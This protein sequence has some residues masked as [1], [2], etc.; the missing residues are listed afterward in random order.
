MQFLGEFLS[1]CVAFSWTISAIA[2]EIAGRR[3]GVVVLNVWR[4]ILALI[5][6]MLLCQV[7]TGEAFP[8]YAD[9]R[10]WLWLLLSGVVG[11]F[12]GD[13]CLFNCYLTVGARYGQLFM[14]LAPMFTAL[15]AWISLGQQLSWQ[16]LL[17]MVVTMSGIVV[18]VLGRSEGKRVSL[19]LPLKGVLFGVGAGLG[20]GLGLVLSK[21]GLDYYTAGVPTDVL[22]SMETFLPFSANGIRCIAGMVCYTVWMLVRHQSGVLRSSV[23]DA[24]GFWA[25]IAAVVTG[26]FVGV[27]LSLM[28]VQYTAA[29]IASTIMAISPIL[30][31]LPSYYI[32]K[33]P[34]TL[35][36]VVGAV[37]S[38]V[39]V[40]LFF[41]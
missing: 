19:Q 11:Y 18:S 17:A 38:V 9:S 1:L 21:V 15:A 4:M 36:G 30:I 12:F 31:I 2:C 10:A 8:V 28:A 32:F 35:R 5:F 23:F 16:A 20:Q 27:G 40:S 33:Q 13:W 3:M 41:L 26:P 34:I 14:T 6:S 29:G 7:F 24:K 22:P 37:I 39:G 25:M